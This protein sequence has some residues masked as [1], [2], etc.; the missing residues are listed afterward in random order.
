MSLPLRPPR[1]GARA[2]EPRVTLGVGPTRNGVRLPA[3][4]IHPRA[5]AP[6]VLV[7]TPYGRT[8]LFAEARAW[9][10][11]G[12]AFVVQDVRGRGDAGGEWAPWGPHEREDA[13]ATARWAV[14]QPF[15][16]GRLVTVGTSYE[17]RLAGLTA[18]EEPT[19]VR[20]VARMLPLDLPS[21][22]DG[23]DGA[24]CAERLWW[25]AAQAPGRH[26][27]P[28]QVAAR[29]SEVE[30]A[31]DEDH[32]MALLGARPIEAS[33]SAS[34]D[35]TTTHGRPTVHVG[36]WFDPSLHAV[37]RAT[38]TRTDAT[39]AARRDRAA[40]DPTDRVVVGPWQLPL[41]RRPIDGCLLDTTGTGHPS[42]DALRFVRAVLDGVRPPPDR[43]FVLGA[44]WQDGRPEP[45]PGRLRPGA[46]PTPRWSAIPSGRVVA[47]PDGHPL[48]DAVPGV[49][50]VPLT[51]MGGVSSL[52][53]MPVVELEVRGGPGTRLIA[54]L[55]LRDGH[56]ITGARG[57]V[58]ST[59]GAA[60]VRGPLTPIAVGMRP[61][62]AME[63]HLSRSWWPQY[64]SSRSGATV[65]E[66]RL[67]SASVTF[68]D[69]WL[70]LRR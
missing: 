28:N 35:A 63:L 42:R 64:R 61:G 37:L 3:D 7:Q 22:L 26:P 40:P 62:S 59:G 6:V 15:S 31:R 55:G 56:R 21:D 39:S 67:D 23:G 19:L 46:G 9:A 68:H 16:D 13:A 30:Q 34:A 4:V 14:E 70:E 47:T 52:V 58:A 24:R 45:T 69:P 25:W 27:R 8:E 60:R 2:P 41:H 1:P 53:G 33:S 32:A 48:P 5:P 66:V 18:D 57:T 44:G 10:R 20:A 51:G 43:T 12:F 50:V 17:A 49:T 54:R 11:A 29:W 38:R 65:V 36:S